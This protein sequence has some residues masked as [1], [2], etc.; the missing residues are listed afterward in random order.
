MLALT[1]I[2]ACTSA[3]PRP[4]AL[5]QGRTYTE[6]LFGRQFDKLWGRFS[7]EMQ[8]T[9]PSVSELSAFVGQTTGELGRERGTATERM[10]RLGSTE[11]YTRTAQF[12]RAARPVEVQWT[13]GGDGL[14]TGL[15][16]HPVAADSAP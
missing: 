2:T 9:F 10:T 7:P 4:T 3:A 15:L 11:V 1:L 8:K 5:E 6:W 12:E 14:V 13:M 16:V